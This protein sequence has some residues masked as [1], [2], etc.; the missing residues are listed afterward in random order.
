MAGHYDVATPGELIGRDSSGDLM[1]AIRLPT[2][3]LGN[4]RQRSEKI[5]HFTAPPVPPC[6]LFH[7]RELG[8]SRLRDADSALR[9]IRCESWLPT[10]SGA[11]RFVL[12]HGDRGRP[13]C[14]ESSR[15]GWRF[16]EGGLK[17]R[18]SLSSRGSL[19]NFPLTESGRC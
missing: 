17:I 6:P 13:P 12:P 4:G 1:N 14:R 3:R 19:I 2:H 8:Q 5:R 7:R 11:K 15:H 9:A 18:R 16:R 10:G